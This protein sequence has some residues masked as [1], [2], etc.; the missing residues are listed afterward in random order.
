MSE[1]CVVVTENKKATHTH[2]CT[3]THDYRGAS[4]FALSAMHNTVFAH[5]RTSIIDD[6]LVF[7]KLFAFFFCFVLFCCRRLNVGGGE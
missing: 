6:F 1:L 4:C 5:N 2:A 7:L 3:D